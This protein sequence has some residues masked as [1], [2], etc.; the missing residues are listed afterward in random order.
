M[1][2]IYRLDLNATG[3][4]EGQQ[5]ICGFVTKRDRKVERQ[6]KTVCGRCSAVLMGKYND[7]A[8]DLRSVSS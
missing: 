6:P 1:I 3:A 2:H 8:Q 4:V 5:A 7:V